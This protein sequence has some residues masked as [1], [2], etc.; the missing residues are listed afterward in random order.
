MTEDAVHSRT[1]WCASYPKSGNTWVRSLVQALRSGASPDIN[2][3]SSDGHAGEDTMRGLG[4]SVS[5][6]NDLDAH[7]FLRLGWALERHADDPTASVLRKTHTAWLPVADGYPQCWQP[8]GGRAVYIVR[9]PRAVAVSWAHHI[10]HSNFD[11][12]EIMATD[13]T[14]VPVRSDED[15]RFH[16]GN[17]S[18]HVASWLDQT[19]LPTLVLRYEDL[20]ENPFDTVAN[21][22]QWLGLPDDPDQLNPAIDSCSFEKL[23]AAEIVEGFA[24]AA[25]PD[26]VF[27][28]R[29]ETA[30]WRTELEPVLIERIEREH[31]DVMRRLG[32]L[33]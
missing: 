1:V 13:R 20:S 15:L 11:A 24:E 28:R 4:L 32:Y 21:L 22:A 16:P 14:D 8:V 18:T 25:A 17:W 31:A 3:L 19:E 5:D 23:A 27:F 7:G 29:G 10:G 12:V 9:D 2:R 33:S 30:S 26:R 6:M